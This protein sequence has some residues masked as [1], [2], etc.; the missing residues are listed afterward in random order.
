MTLLP[1]VYS[2]AI[3]KHLCDNKERKKQL[4]RQLWR[5]NLHSTLTNKKI[6]KIICSKQFIGVYKTFYSQS[7]L[8][9]IL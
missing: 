6:T 7:I 4:C 2:F 5:L 3:F 8:K 1:V 9:N